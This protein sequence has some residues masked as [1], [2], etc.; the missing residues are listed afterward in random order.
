[1]D[2]TWA[3][4]DG[5]FTFDAGKEAKKV[6]Y[7][8]AAVSRKAERKGEGKEKGKKAEADDKGEMRALVLAD[9]EALADP[10]MENA[11]N[12]VF[13]HDTLRWLAGDAAAQGTGTVTSEEDTPVQHTRDQDVYWFYGTVFAAPALALGAGL[14]FV[15]WRRRGR[16]AR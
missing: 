3:D 6:Y 16:A 14:S 11:G 13:A 1:M 5:N 9:G 7:L 4:V 12:L 2:G 15:R 8:A 10:M